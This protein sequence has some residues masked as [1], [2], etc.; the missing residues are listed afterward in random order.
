MP[1][2]D[3]ALKRKPSVDLGFAASSSR[4]GGSGLDPAMSA[5]SAPGHSTVFFAASVASLRNSCES[6]P[7]FLFLKP[8]WPV[9]LQKTIENPN[10]VAKGTAMLGKTP[11]FSCFHHHFGRWNHGFNPPFATTGRAPHWWGRMM[12][13][14]CSTRAAPPPTGGW[15]VYRTDGYGYL[16]GCRCMRLCMHASNWACIWCV[17]VCVYLS[18]SLSIYLSVCLSVC[19]SIYLSIYLSWIYKALFRRFIRVCVCVRVCFYK[20]PSIVIIFPRK[21]LLRA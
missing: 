11:I 12:E 9:K 3:A 1:K 18:I 7:C 19:L 14:R 6:N 2:N 13:G 5:M 4:S 21:L 15:Y 8:F 16:D 10:F 20:T 17:C